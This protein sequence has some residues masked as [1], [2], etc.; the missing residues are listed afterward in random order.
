MAKANTWIEYA[1]D[2][3]HAPMA[4]WVHVH[5]DGDT[6]SKARH[7]LPPAPTPVA[8]K[9]Y[10]IL[11]VDAGS[12]TLH[13][14]SAEQLRECIRVLEMVPLPTTRRL[15]ALRGEALG[16]NSHWLSRLPASIKSPKARMRLVKVLKQ[17]PGSEDGGRI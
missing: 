17:C 6:W 11:F 13:F 15:S 4:Y 1:D 2:W 5:Q 9:G 3:R 7:Y 12:V 14:S 10:P 8:G 16:P